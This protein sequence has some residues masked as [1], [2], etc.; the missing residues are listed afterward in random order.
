LAD[1][2][3]SKI[4]C[5]ITPALPSDIDDIVLARVPTD[6]SPGKDIFPAAMNAALLR[7][8][9]KSENMVIIGIRIK[10]VLEDTADL[11]MRLAC[12]AIEKD[13]LIIVLSY[14]DYCGL[15]RFGFRVERVS[16]QNEAEQK[17]C[18]DD[19]RNFWGISM[20]I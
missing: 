19:I 14:L 5:L 8:E 17:I 13:V 6:T 10:S 18:E 1:Q 2:G 4:I 20:I 11:A 9:Q 7:P 3:Y 16:G 15:E 12:L